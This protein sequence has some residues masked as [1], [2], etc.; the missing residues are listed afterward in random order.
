VN[1][2]DRYKLHSINPEPLGQIR[3]GGNGNS[4]GKSL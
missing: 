2:E 4:A 1:P 3:S